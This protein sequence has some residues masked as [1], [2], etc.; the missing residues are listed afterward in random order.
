MDTPGKSSA[1]IRISRRE[2]GDPSHLGEWDGT[3]E[4]LSVVV[5]DPIGPEGRI[6][7]RS[8][9]IGRDHPPTDGSTRA[10]DQGG[11]PDAGRKPLGFDADHS[12]ESVAS[13]HLT[14]D[15]H[16]TTPCYAETASGGANTKVRLQIGG[17]ETHAVAEAI[18][19]TVGEVSQGDAVLGV[20]L[21]IKLDA[22]IRASSIIIALQNGSVGIG[23]GE[24]RVEAGSQ[25]TGSDFN[26]PLL[27][28]RGLEAEGIH[29]FL[30]TDASVDDPRQCQVLGLVRSVVGFGFGGFVQ[31]AHFEAHRIGESQRRPSADLLTTERC[32]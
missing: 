5:A 18:A 12:V 23:K 6:T 7:Q 32:V 13:I 8:V 25:G 3:G 17:L 20:F 24:K 11:S 10:Q 15:G 2:N 28:G 31:V 9:R 27:I 29:I 22:G 21:G 26:D 1:R 30:G 19:A 4:R 14:P 16:R